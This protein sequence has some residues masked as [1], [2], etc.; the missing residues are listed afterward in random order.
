MS[1]KVPSRE[2]LK[3]F[4]PDHESIVQFE[5]LFGSS[6][7]LEQLITNIIESTGLNSSDGTYTASTLAHYINVATDLF[8]ADTILDQ[9]IFDYSKDEIISTSTSIS[10]SAKNQTI[11]ADA[12]SGVINITL[13]NPALSHINNRSY[14]IGVTKSDVTTNRVNILPYGSELVVGEASQFL[15]VDGEVLNFITDGTNWYLGA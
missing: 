13:P 6:S 3:K 5:K 4:L 7:S 2:Q 1:L 9:A 14:K 12:T 15:D 11:I 8:N 10:L